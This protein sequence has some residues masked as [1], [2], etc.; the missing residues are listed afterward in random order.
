MQQF[1]RLRPNSIMIGPSILRA[2]LSRLADACTDLLKA[3]ADYLHLDVMDGHFV[4]NLTFGHP[5]VASLRPHLPSGTFLD[6]HMM[7]SEPEKWI[8]GMKAAGASQYIFHYEATKNVEEC[9]N[10]VRQSGMKVGISIKPRTP[11]TDILP[12]IKAVDT[13]LIMTVEPGFG[14]QKFMT[15]M[16]PKVKHL[17]EH[18]A[19]L[20]IEVDGGIT[21]TTIRDCVAAGAN[22]FVSGAEITD[23]PDPTAMIHLLHST[24]K[25]V[26]ESKNTGK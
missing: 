15:D 26:I 20:N 8:D 25:E 13:V 4:P 2:D 3:G 11:V 6:V 21:S 16:L 24:A 19:D 9:I 5:V 23:S 14:G 22:M 7:V 18:Y 12:Y 17:R 10:L 1:P